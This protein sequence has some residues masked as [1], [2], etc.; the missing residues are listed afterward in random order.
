MEFSYDFN[1]AV[2]ALNK[3]LTAPPGKEPLTLQLNIGVKS[4]SPFAIAR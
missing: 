3:R 1:A 4:G 2:I